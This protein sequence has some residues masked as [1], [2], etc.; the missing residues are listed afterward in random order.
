MLPSG[1]LP[2]DPAEAPGLTHTSALGP[3][4]SPA[5]LEEGVQT[6]KHTLFS[7]SACA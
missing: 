4:L 7:K 2:E 6:L 1:T 5:I 3:V